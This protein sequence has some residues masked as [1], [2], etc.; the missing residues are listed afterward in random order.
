MAYFNVFIPIWILFS[1]LA[2]K[3]DV[4][5][6]H[7]I[8][9]PDKEVPASSGNKA[10]LLSCDCTITQSGQ[11]FAISA[12][13]GTQTA[14]TF[15]SPGGGNPNTG[16][17]IQ[18]A[19][20]LFLY[21]NVNTGIISLFLI[22]DIAN[23]GTGG[24]LMADVTCLPS[25]AFVSV[26]DE[27]GE[28]SGAPP[29]ISGDWNW[30]PCCTDGGVIEDI[31]CNNTYINLDVLVGSGIDSIVWLTGD[32]SNPDQILLSLN[33]GAITISCGSGAVCCPPSLDT[34]V[35]VTDA[36]CPDTPNGSIDINPQDGIPGYTYDWSNGSS[37]EDLTGLFPGVYSVT[38]SDSQGCI[39]ELEITVDISP[40]DPLAQ[41]VDLEL[42][43]ETTTAS[44]DL[45][46]V[47][48]IINLGTGFDV[49]WFQN[50]DLTG[51]ILN[52]S[53]YG[54][55]T[56]TVYAVVDN[57]PCLSEPVPVELT[58]LQSPIGTP[59]TMDICEESEEMA[60]FDLTSLEPIV[61]GG[62][63]IVYWYLDPAATNLINNPSEFLSGSTTVYA[64]VDDNI[65][66][67]EPVEIE[68]IVN[69]KPEV[70]PTSFNLCGDEN[71]EAVF[72][73]ISIEDDISAG[74]G[75]VDW[76]LEIELLD[77]IVFPGSFLSPT[78]IIYAVVYDG[79][80]YADPIPIQLIVD[81]T[82]VAIPITI[83]AC[84]E[85]SGIGLFNLWDY[86]VQVSGGEGNVDW[87]FDE[88]LSDP[89]PNP[90]A[91]LTA[92]TVI[93]ATVDN[94]LCVS[95]YVQIQLDVLQSP[96]GN[97]ST[98]ETCADST[99]Q[100]V[101]NLTSADL[102]ISGGNGM[103]LWFED[104]LGQILIAM[105]EAYV[106]SGEFVYAQIVSG[107]CLSDF[108]PIEL[109]L[110]TSVA[111]DPAQLHACDDGTGNGLFNLPSVADS[112]SGGSGQVNW[113]FDSMGTNPI[114]NPSNFISGDSIIYAQVIAGDCASDIVPVTLMIIPAPIAMDVSLTFCGDSSAQA[115]IDLTS[116]DTLISGH[117]GSVSWFSD[118]LLMM[119]IINTFAFSTSDTTLYATVTAGTCTSPAAAVSIVVTSGLMAQTT[120]IDLCIP[121]GDTIPI[122]L[123]LSDEIINGGT[124][125]VD[126][127]L[128]TLG[129]NAIS[130]P[131]TFLVSASSTVF[132]A[133]FNAGC[134]SPT[135]PV[136]LIVLPT[137]VAM[138]TNIDKC[139]DVN[140]MVTLD[141]TEVDAL[142]SSNTGT[143]TWY[144][145][146]TL[147]TLLNSPA[148][149]VT[150]DTTVFA[151]VTNVF[152]A[153]SAVPVS[154]TVVDSLTAIP[155]MIDICLLDADTAL[156][157]LT[158]YDL[159]ISGGS[160][161]VIWCRDSLMLDTIFDPTAFSTAG[162]TLYVVITADDCTSNIS[163]V[164]LAVASSSYPMA[165]CAFTSIDSVGVT[166]LDVADEFELTYM[167]NGQFAG[168]PIMTMNN[169]FNLGGLGQGDTLFISIT[170]NYD[171]ICTT[172]LTSTI[173]CITDVCP[174]QPLVL[175]GLD[176]AYCRDENFVLLTATPTGGLFSGQ[177][178]SGDTL[179]PGYVIG[180]GT[181]VM[182]S[183]EAPSSDCIYDTTVLVSIANPHN[184]PVL[185]CAS[186]TTDSVTFSWDNSS[187]TYGY[188]YTINQATPSSTVVG[189][190]NSLF[191]DGLNEGDEV[192]LTL[193]A[194]GAPPCGNSDTITASCVSKI[195]PQATITISD[196]GMFCSVDDPVQLDA[197]I[198][199]LPGQPTIIW[200]GPGISDPSGIFDPMLASS[201]M[202]IV[203]VDVE[204]EGCRYTS[205][206]NITVQEQ[207]VA[208]FTVSGEPCLDQS[209]LVV[210]D[211]VASA[212][213]TFQ[214]DLAGAAVVSG[215]IPLSFSIAWSDTGAY[216]LSLVIDDHGCVSG[217]SNEAVVIGQPL[218]APVIICMEEDYTSV[219][220][221]WEDVPG[222][223]SYLASS[224]SGNGIVSGN[225]F[226]ITNLKDDTPVTIT[227][228]PLGGNGCG[229]LS[230]TITCHT[231]AYSP[232]LVY[233]ANVFSP[234]ADGINDV[235][236]IQTN[237]EVTDVLSF[238]IFD[239]WG[240]VVFED[241]NFLPN[242]LQHGWDG[243]F[244]GKIMNAA[245]F[246]YIA[247]VKTTRGKPLYLRGDITL[248]R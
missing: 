29:I 4:H 55:G 106:S 49:L 233:I 27:P 105:P 155:Q 167:I 101:F 28:F 147:A 77:P 102:E 42:C 103:V 5:Q 119:G 228:T 35:V 123:T 194:V 202:N 244:D 57:G 196:P 71:D 6:D 26:S 168:S 96:V 59:T 199:G 16:L 174:V 22:L 230:S 11:S 110:I 221:E 73:L 83:T 175:N 162:D 107:S 3:T 125:T 78:A 216:L 138:P 154:I 186:D 114:T 18:E 163:A 204:D 210:F 205:T 34:E 54:T 65:C 109:I 68:L 217:V 120:S 235:V 8:E 183:W 207:P 40:G 247:E 84:D 122:D 135:V 170:A 188:Y 9:L 12:L 239:R 23:D 159:M 21:E 24:S 53:N 20:I 209:L 236:Y 240:T 158:M 150:G 100:G 51:P 213:A 241:F 197:T 14:V 47:N 111:A 33:G 72:D 139:G 94:D 231:L 79:L 176:S 134:I 142:V 36:T 145:D 52:P 80:C 225:T 89:V 153:S 166:W 178:V 129:I 98:I 10:P 117:S 131:N 97:P 227:V 243:V 85:G 245:V 127:Y 181:S 185:M 179:Y 62:N 31:G 136:D 171:S 226:T 39:E 218:P 232:P 95:G 189:T 165:A 182:Y 25:T 184:A 82:P 7:I 58:V 248:L 242:D 211:G 13:Q 144:V 118:T 141:L 70:F 108:I 87:Y 229:S 17:E 112:V 50:I 88:F 48:D 41:A 91:L 113:Y 104:P 192:S 37:D 238:R 234:D 90:T 61:S 76:Y 208:A 172:P 66:A 38:V 180:A 128:D 126:W 86:A 151:V 140:G 173:T 45:T 198:V 124:G 224:S 60:T 161:S 130:F 32:I 237:A 187:L 115:I 46:I 69:L 15:F 93:F 149:L 148:M 246:T 177:G 133:V 160:G 164:V 156:V 203:T 81:P 44:F 223:T 152:C 74:N 206:I 56:S 75:S 193:W 99:G 121:A 214:Y 19:L 43:S 116:L 200:T 146:P 191:V 132:A 215:L 30:A 92:S 143:V 219:V 2:I 157:N 63:G 1:G 190:Q 137:P 195:C 169:E 67:S 212:S 64:V 201:G 220:V 222:A